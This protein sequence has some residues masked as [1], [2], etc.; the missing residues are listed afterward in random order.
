M[1]L[2][3]GLRM[4]VPSFPQPHPHHRRGSVLI[5]TRQSVHENRIYSLE[6]HC[7]SEYPDAPPTVRF[8]TKINLPGVGAS[9][10]KVCLCPG[11]EEE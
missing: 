9:D 10:G 8:L 6:I 3:W 1:Q 7:G 2:F 11:V 4:F 5:G